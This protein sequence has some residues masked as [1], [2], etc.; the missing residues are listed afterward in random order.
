VGFLEISARPDPGTER[1]KVEEL[2]NERLGAELETRLKAFYNPGV[3]NSSGT[4]RVASEGNRLVVMPTSSQELSEDAGVAGDGL[5]RNRDPI[6]SV[7]RPFEDF[8][9]DEM[10]QIFEFDYPRF[11]EEALHEVANQDP[12]YTF[13]EEKL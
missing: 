1:A 7:E 6:L 9:D 2:T 10:R 8:I 11:L 5:D 4:V 12:R 3:L 13:E